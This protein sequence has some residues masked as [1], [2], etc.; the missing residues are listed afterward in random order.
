MSDSGWKAAELSDKLR[1]GDV[2]ANLEGI[3][4]DDPQVGDVLL[5]CE[6]AELDEDA[7]LYQLL[8]RQ[9][10]TDSLRDARLAG[11]VTTMN[12]A[13]G[14]SDTRIEATGYDMLVKALK[15]AAQQVLIKGPKGSGKTTKALDLT[16]HLHAEMDGDLSVLTNIKRSDGEEIRHDAVDYADTLS[17]MLEWVRDTP[18]EKL[19]IG[20]E[21]SS[22]VNAHAHGGGEVRAS[23]SRFINALR[24]GEG[25]STRL[26]VIGHEHDTDIAAILRTQSDVVIQAD[27]KVDDGLIDC[28][29][30]YDGWEDYQRE[31]HWFRVRGLRDVPHSSDWGVST[32]YFATFELDL[33]DP[34]KQIKRGRLVED[35]QQYQ[36]DADD[37]E[38]STPERVTCRGLK[39]SGD[40]CNQLTNHESGF[41]AHHRNQWDGDAD[42]R[43]T[44]DD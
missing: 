25:G 37:E 19:V 29:T 43:L 30:V 42:P 44:E 10:A 28:A 13:T 40:D 5:A 8:S 24:K 15:P 9:T 12:T 2:D 39:T 6:R 36:D 17:G 31:D 18:G 16:R 41:C 3:L 14:L 38:D 1:N 22:T 23:F 33:D 35:W 32:N 21:W 7:P 20:D 4:A 11:D 26:I 27:G 34:E